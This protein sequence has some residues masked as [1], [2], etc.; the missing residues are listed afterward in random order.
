[1]NRQ[2]KREGMRSKKKSVKRAAVAEAKA[3]V[4]QNAAAV[5]KK[6]DFHEEQ[7]KALNA[8]G[9]STIRER[10]ADVELLDRLATIAVL[11][12]KRALGREMSAEEIA[13]MTEALDG[14]SKGESDGATSEGVAGSAAPVSGD[15][16][17]GEQLGDDVSGG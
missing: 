9:M 15:D 12:L 17:S 14:P 16:V 1:M 5:M 3:A 6:L 13:A 11:L 2:A 7:L 4:S 10:Q 8:W